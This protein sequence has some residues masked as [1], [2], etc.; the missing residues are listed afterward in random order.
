M[1]LKQ[2]AA[3]MQQRAN[4]LPA[5]V[6]EVKKEVSGTV[7]STVALT[8]PV[9]TGAAVSSWE[10]ELGA[11]KPRANAPHTPGRQGSTRAENVRATISKGNQVI[12]QAKP[13]D[14]V[15]I[16]NGIEYIGD[17]NNGTSTQAPAGF[18]QSAVLNGRRKVRSAK[19]IKR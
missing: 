1:D 14:P 6:N 4:E 11:G 16:T 10:V 7:L 15:H 12:S 13:G 5:N 2:F 9:D 8:T 3:L 17:L 19:V 18:V